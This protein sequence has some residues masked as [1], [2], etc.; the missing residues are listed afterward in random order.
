MKAYQ[1]VEWGKPLEEREVPIPEPQ[2]TEVLVKVVASGICHSDIHIWDGYFDL[3]GGEKITLEGRG[4]G[5]P[6][7]MG[8]E[9]AGEVAALGPEASGVSVGDR[10]I[11][12]PWIGCGNCEVCQRG[13][14]LLCLTP[15]IIGTRKNGGYAEYCLVPDAKYLIDYEGVPDAHAATC[16]CSGL[17]ALSA[18]KKVDFLRPADHL[19]IVGAGGVGLAAAGMAKSLVEAKLIV[20]DIDPDKRAAALDAGADAVIDN[21]EE[22]ASAKL[23]EMTSGGPLAAIDF[24]GA[25]ATSGLAIQSLARGATLVVVGLYGGKLSLSLVMLPLKML[26]IIG[27]YVGTLE[28]MHE[29][30]ALVKAG[31]VS[32]VPTTERPLSK[33]P[34]AI[35]DLRAGK[36]VGRYV[37]T[38]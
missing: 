36:T 23:V 27:S 3:G 4:V 31:K 19:L 18:L 8:H 29:L 12:F 10:R 37:L 33:A 21:G 35:A 16:A 5:L 20:A 2:G 38:A 17:T 32:P 14:E 22:D 13:D 24:V 9:V 26:R 1:I 15:R 7:T 34:Q 30:M 11:V 25:P 28:E 6:F